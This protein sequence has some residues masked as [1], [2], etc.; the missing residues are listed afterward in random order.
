MPQGDDRKK[1]DE[2]DD[3]DGRFKDTS[4]DIAKATP[5]CTRVSAPAP[6]M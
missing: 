6:R 4:R 1:A 3:D 2:P 5:N